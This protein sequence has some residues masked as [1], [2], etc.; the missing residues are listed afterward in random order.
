MLC[1]HFWYRHGGCLGTSAKSRVGVCCCGGGRQQFVGA[2]GDG[3]WRHD[4][5]HTARRTGEGQPVPCRVTCR[6]LSKR[7]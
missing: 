4:N 5:S 2:N 7:P 1:L 3:P 6:C